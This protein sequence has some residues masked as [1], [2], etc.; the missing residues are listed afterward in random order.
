MFVHIIPTSPY[1]RILH[2]IPFHFSVVCGR[3]GDQPIHLRPKYQF[4]RLFRD[5]IGKPILFWKPSSCWFQKWKSLEPILISTKDIWKNTLF[6]TKYY[7]NLG[8]ELLFLR[9]YQIW[10]SRPSWLMHLTCNQEVLGLNQAGV[11]C[12]FA[13]ANGIVIAMYWCMHYYCDNANL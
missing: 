7:M 2:P 3:Q 1:C 4:S 10:V 9:S 6:S 12:T 8:I 13:M 11:E 5:S